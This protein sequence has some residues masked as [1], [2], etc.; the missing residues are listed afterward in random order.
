MIVDTLANAGVYKNTNPR[1]EKALKYLLQTDFE[2]LENGKYAVDGDDVFAIVN[3]FETRDKADCEIEAHR[4]YI[5]IQYIVRGVEMFGYAPLAGHVPIKEYDE[6]NDVA[7]YKEEVSY[8]KLE[9][10]M[11]ILFLPSDLHQPEV[12]QYEPVVVKKVVMKIKIG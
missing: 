10:G 6:A 5:D 11:F 12:R 2:Q 8:I 9:A 4:K 7:I 3:E 1:I